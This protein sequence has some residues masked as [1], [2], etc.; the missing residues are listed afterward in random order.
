MALEDAGWD[1]FD[2]RV[3]FKKTLNLKPEDIIVHKT[4]LEAFEGSK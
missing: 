1:L 2:S 3:M 4:H